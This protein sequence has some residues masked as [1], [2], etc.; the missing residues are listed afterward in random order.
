MTVNRDELIAGAAQR[1]KDPF[2]R[3][4][5]LVLATATSLAVIATL[6]GGYLLWKE[7]QHQAEAGMSLAV[8]V[9][10][11][12]EDPATAVHLGSICTKAEHVEQAIAAGPQGPPGDRGPAGADGVD[13]RDGRDGI[14]GRD[15]APGKNG[16]NGLN[17][18]D[19]HDGAPGPVGPQGLEGPQG[20]PGKDGADGQDGAPAFPMQWT[21]EFSPNP[22]QN[23]S[24]LCV[25]LDPSQKVNCTQ[26]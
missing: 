7:K 16:R 14:N 1:G 23:Y 6:L 8:Q 17:G 20:P 22:A 15:G 11:A 21:F 25:L 26:Q 24:F 4:L 10:R 2:S 19:G 18:Q 12:C 3:K 5:L 13:G 9:Q